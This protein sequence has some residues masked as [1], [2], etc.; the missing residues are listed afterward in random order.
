MTEPN[1]QSMSQPKLREYV[2]MHPEDIEA[3]HYY[4]DKLRTQTGV[5]ISTEEELE[6]ELQKRIEAR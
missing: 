4:V 5:L 3:F 1:Y 2:R 6:Q